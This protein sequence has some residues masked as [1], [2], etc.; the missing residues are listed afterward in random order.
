MVPVTMPTDHY[1]NLKLYAYNKDK[2]PPN[3]Q[4]FKNFLKTDTSLAFYLF[5]Y[6]PLKRFVKRREEVSVLAKAAESLISA[7]VEKQAHK[8]YSQSSISSSKTL[9]NSPTH[10]SKEDL[11]AI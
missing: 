3:S 7:T 4:I 10:A 6:L 2:K 1:R 11:S 9:I 8:P 5:I